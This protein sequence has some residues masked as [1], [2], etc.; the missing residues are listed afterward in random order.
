MASIVNQQS[1]SFLRWSALGVG[2][3]WGWTR[4]HS[5]TRLVKDR[6]AD[7]EKAHHNLLVEEARVAYEAHYNKTQNALAKKD[8]VASCDSDS[9]FFDAD[10]WSNWAVA[11]NDAEDAAAKL[12]AK[13]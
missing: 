1:I 4:H 5:L 3:W 12:S 10:K 6:A 9:I 2:V 7:T 11:Q 8:G 13:K